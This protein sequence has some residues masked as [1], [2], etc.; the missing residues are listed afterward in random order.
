MDGNGLC[1]VARSVFHIWRHRL[2]LGVGAIRCPPSNRPQDWSA[3]AM[4]PGA[5]IAAAIEV[6]E[7]IEARKRPAAD[8]LKDWGLSHRF[9][10]SKD[11]A[12]VA[13]LVFDAQRKR[14]SSAFLLGG[15]SP[16]AS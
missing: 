14:A 11:R 1:A 13:S 10:G 9:A 4:T 12:A 8:A 15:A 16:R 5:R 3:F 2:V 7:A 6:V